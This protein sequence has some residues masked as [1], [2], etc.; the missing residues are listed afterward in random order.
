[1]STYI[2]HIPSELLGDISRGECLPVIGA[3]FST[4]ATLPSG[5]TMPL[6]RDL[7]T[8]VAKRLGRSPCSDPK[9]DLSEYCEKFMKF[10][11]VRNLWD[12]LHINEAKPGTAHLSFARLPF[13]QVLTTNFDFLL[14]KAYEASSRAYL[15]VVGEDLLPF[16]LI[17]GVTR[18]IKMHGDLHHPSN[19]VLTEDDYDNFSQRHREMVLTVYNLLVSHT[20]LFIGYSVDDPDLRQ[21]W[22]LVK[23]QFGK[24]RRPA[25]ALVVG[26]TARLTSKYHRRGVTHVISLPGKMSNYGAVLTR[27]FQELSIRLQNCSR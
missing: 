5:R 1:M 3:G 6:W 14:E 13:P 21:I 8:E 27:L 11:L 9:E 12:W 2:K 4:N 22:G 25:Y 16:G 19:L 20:P 24:F 17:D 10:E 23:D 18:I 7:G 15:P 26:P